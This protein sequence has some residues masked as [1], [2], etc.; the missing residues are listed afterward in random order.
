MASNNLSTKKIIGYAI[1]I[2]GS[3]FFVAPSLYAFCYYTK[4]NIDIFNY[5]SI[6]EIMVSYLSKTLLMFFCMLAMLLF[7]FLFHARLERY[8]EKQEGDK[9]KKKIQSQMKALAVCITFLLI[10]L[11]FLSTTSFYCK[12]D[13]AIIY[14]LGALA[15]YS[16]LALLFFFPIFYSNNKEKSAIYAGFFIFLF[17]ISTYLLPKYEVEQMIRNHGRD[18]SY[19]IIFRDN[20]LLKTSDSVFYIGKTL[21]YVFIHHYDKAGYR[22]RTSVINA[23]DVKEIN[24][25]VNVGQCNILP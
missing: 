24:A 5:I 18:N 17:F 10:L 8:I 9:E 4:F 14:L 15:C 25:L 2:A 13:L 3:F 11:A 20:T 6:S 1:I 23:S 21:H 12:I 19:E 22:S 7:V 16:F